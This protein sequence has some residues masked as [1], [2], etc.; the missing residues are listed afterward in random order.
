M[1]LESG[2]VVRFYAEEGLKLGVV[3]V[4][5]S[6]KLADR[7]GYIIRVNGKN[8]P[9]SEQS[10]QDPTPRCPSCDSENW[11]WTVGGEFYLPEDVFCA[12]CEPPTPDWGEAWRR[13]VKLIKLLPVGDPNYPSIMGTMRNC[14]AALEAGDWL[15]FQRYAFVMGLAIQAVLGEWNPFEPE[16]D[17]PFSSDPVDS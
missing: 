10:V 12:V 2:Q 1:K 9:A 17:D 14:D 3:L 6:S 15:K 5:T 11:W 13:L 8:H 4:T 7:F 16:D